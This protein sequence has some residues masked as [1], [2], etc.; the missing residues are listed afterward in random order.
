MTQV[1]PEATETTPGSTSPWSRTSSAT[2]LGTIR[3]WLVV[4]LLLALAAVA[5]VVTAARPTPRMTVHGFVTIYGLSG[6]E[7]P[8]AEC[9]QPLFA[10]RPVTVF[11]DDGTAVGA[12]AL[13]GRGT[14]T[15]RWQT[16]AGGYADACRYEITVPDVSATSQQYSVAVGTRPGEGVGFDRDQL[17]T[18]NIDLP[19]GHG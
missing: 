10:G 11:D 18:A 13:T 2:R 12:T 17:L 14:A 6:F 9:A 15:D 4:G 5:V 19:Y 16:F 1:Q 8:G 3:P 7:R